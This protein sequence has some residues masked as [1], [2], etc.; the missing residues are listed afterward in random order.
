MLILY[1]MHHL[2]M[3]SWRTKPKQDTHGIYDAY[4]N[5][6]ASLFLALE[7]FTSAVLDYIDFFPEAVLTTPWLT[8]RATPHRSFMTQTS[9]PPW[10]VFLGCLDKPH[11]GVKTGGVQTEE[12]QTLIHPQGLH[13]P[14]DRGVNCIFN[15]TLQHAAA[16][17]NL[18]VSTIVPLIK[19]SAVTCINYHLIPLS[20]LM[21]CFERMILSFIK[22]IIPA[23]LHAHHYRGCYRHRTSFTLSHLQQPN[24]YIRM[25]FVDFRSALNT[26]IPHKLVN[27]TPTSVCPPHSVHGL[28]TF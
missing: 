18:N 8:T 27:N 11:G 28:W 6:T 9:L 26:V 25:L 21:K 7:T 15:L 22:D 23:D 12:E 4:A 10:I 13:W 5:L 16:P 14:V 20:L 2:R 3:H 17:T 24:T 1:L 19:K